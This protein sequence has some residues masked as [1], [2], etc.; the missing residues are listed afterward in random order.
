MQGPGSYT[1]TVKVTDNGTP[2][3]S[4]EEKIT[5]TVNEVNVAPVLAAIG[6]QTVDEL[7]ELTFTATAT[8]A[9]GRAGQHADLQPGRRAGGRGD[10]PGDRRVPLDAERGARRGQLHVHGEGDGQRHAAALSDDEEITVTVN[11]VNV[12][13]VLD[14]IG[15]KTVDEL[16]ELTF[17]A[18][19]DGRRPA[20]QRAD[21]QLGGRA[22]RGEHQP[23]DGRVHVDAQRGPR[24][25]ELHVH[26]EGD[27]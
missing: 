3:V 13:P 7:G 4:D 5:V 9:T 17:T 26:G 1:F 24:S 20:G 14:P 12:A 6:N 2:A 15:N 27:R 23:D 22:G 10:R 16:V 18:T 8:D 25:G 21:V 19:R 11:E